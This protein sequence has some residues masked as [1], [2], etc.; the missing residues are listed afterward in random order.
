MKDTG[1][2]TL[3]VK[4][5]GGS[6]DPLMATLGVLLK[7][8]GDYASSIETL[9]VSVGLLMEMLRG[10]LVEKYTLTREGLS[11][12]KARKSKMTGQRKPRRPAPIR[13]ISMSPKHVSLSSYI[14]LSLSLPP[15]FFLFLPTPT[16]LL[17]LFPHLSSLSSP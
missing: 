8:T 1:D 15:S 5:L 2:Y 17:V 4:T 3:L 16:S 9:G 10:G 13:V 11:Q 6:V 7:D 12:A 14:A